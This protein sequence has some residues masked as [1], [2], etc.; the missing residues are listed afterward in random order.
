MP[1]IALHSATATLMMRTVTDAPFDALVALVTASVKTF[2]A[3]GGSAVFR[4]FIRRLS[5]PDPMWMREITPS[6][7]MSA[8]NRA[9]N[10]W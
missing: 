3:P 5:V 7:A 9:R 1:P 6:A 10:Q 8:G 4:P 2:E